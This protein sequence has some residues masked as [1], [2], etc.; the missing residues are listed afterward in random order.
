MV[1]PTA[2]P[3]SSK[4]PWP[5][6]CRRKRQA[7]I[8]PRRDPRGRNLRRG[9]RHSWRA[10]IVGETAPSW[11]NTGASQIYNARQTRGHAVRSAGDPAQAEDLAPAPATRWSKNTKR[12]KRQLARKH[13]GRWHAA[14]EGLIYM[15]IINAI[16][17]GKAN[18]FSS[19]HRPKTDAPAFGMFETEYAEEAESDLAQCCPMKVSK[20]RQSREP[21]LTRNK[22]ALAA[23][24]GDQP[25]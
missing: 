20:A 9:G 21:G 19:K 15:K 14:G 7:V 4:G 3:Q 1:K 22:R 24:G 16:E 5:N 12:T 13:D 10:R 23:P 8:D 6:N 11:N 18:L 25:L 2:A 17:F